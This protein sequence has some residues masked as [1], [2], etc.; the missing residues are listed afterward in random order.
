M[1][2]TGFSTFFD[3]RRI[4]VSR[5]AAETNQNSFWSYHLSKQAI[6]HTDDSSH[7]QALKI[8]LCGGLAGVVTWASIFPL[9]MSGPLCRHSPY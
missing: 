4:L 8:M 6:V 3:G 5:A 7:S 2:V 9:G 1:L